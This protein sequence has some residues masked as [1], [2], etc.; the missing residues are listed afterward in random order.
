[1]YDTLFTRHHTTEGPMRLANVWIATLQ[2]LHTDVLN[3][4]DTNS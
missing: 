4:A 2:Q 1:M 3:N